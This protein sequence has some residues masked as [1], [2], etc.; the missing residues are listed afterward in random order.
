MMQLP[1][2]GSSSTATLTVGRALS[3]VGFHRLKSSR[4]YNPH[5]CNLL[6]P[7]LLFQAK[8]IIFMS[9]KMLINLPVRDP[10]SFSRMHIRGKPAVRL[11]KLCR[12]EVPRI[13]QD[14]EQYT[15]VMWL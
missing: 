7:A 1:G 6:S 11:R 3:T 10:S 8:V 14:I 12:F 4:A 9:N 5:Q 13:E 2:V 15:D